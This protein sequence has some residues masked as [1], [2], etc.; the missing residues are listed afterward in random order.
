M[1]DT[2]VHFW[3][4]DRD[5]YSWITPERPRLN[6]NYLPDDFVAATSKT[7]VSGCIAV[8]AAATIA[9]TDFLLALARKHPF[10][11]GVIGWSDLSNPALCDTLD[12]W[13]DNTRLKGVRPMAA[14]L[15]PEW[16]D[17]PSYATALRTLAKRGLILEALVLPHHL[18][19]VANIARTH[20]ALKIIINHAAKPTPDDVQ[21]WAAI[22]DQFADLKNAYCKVSGFTQ[23]SQDSHHYRRIFDQLLKAF[24]PTR[25]LWGSD[26]PV[27]LETSNYAS[28]LDATAA[29]LE[30]LSLEDKAQILTKTALRVY[31]LDAAAGVKRARGAPP[32]QKFGG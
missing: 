24:E 17:Q 4:L 10:I 32:P 2:H 31:R 22:M 23:Q 8:Q 18:P 1:I 20:P 6:Q 12:R 3:Q 26:F 5:D 13:R 29:L 15:G 9:Q 7:A 30:V 27:L 14:G 19:A 11:R 21:I 25:L 28:W 16:L